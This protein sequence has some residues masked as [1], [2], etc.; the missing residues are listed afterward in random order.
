MTFHNI[1]TLITTYHQTNKKYSHYNY[2]SFEHIKCVMS[3]HNFYPTLHKSTYFT[4]RFLVIYQLHTYTRVRLSY[5]YDI[6]VWKCCTEVSFKGEH[7]HAFSIV[8]KLVTIHNN[9]QVA[10]LP[11]WLANII[12]K[13]LDHHVFHSNMH[14]LISYGTTILVLKMC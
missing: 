4:I 11:F 14:L 13:I 9:T 10:F 8:W 12:N 1:Q 7:I 3:L 6:C 2:K 5:N